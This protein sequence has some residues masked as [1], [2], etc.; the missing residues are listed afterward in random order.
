MSGKSYKDAKGRTRWVRNDEIARVVKQLGD[1]LIIGGYPEEHAKRY[2][3][4]AHTISRWPRPVDAL[5]RDED[6][7]SL[8]GVGG[9]ITGYLEEIINTGTTAKF[10]DD[11]YGPP[12]PKSVLELT[13]IDRLGAKTARM[14]FQ[15]HNI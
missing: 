4:I 14:L 15:E 3:Q 13:E 11:Q 12:P 8:P 9:V 2:A 10:D 6:L 7:N 1:Y 5:A